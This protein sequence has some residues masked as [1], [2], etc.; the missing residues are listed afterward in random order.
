MLIS[1][2][3]VNI[4][5]AT[6]PILVA[7]IPIIKIIIEK[8][9]GTH[10]SDKVKTIKNSHNNNNNGVQINGDGNIVG[11]GNIVRNENSNSIVNNS[12][13]SNVSIGNVG[14]NAQVA[15]GTNIEQRKGI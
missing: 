8:K 4:I 6:A 1:A 10:M 2:D 13:F 14:K 15:V 11:N 12:S 9:R 3:I 5:T 7:T